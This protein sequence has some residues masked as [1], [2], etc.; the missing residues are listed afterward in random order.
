MDQA[1]QLD[2]LDFSPISLMSY[3]YWAFISYSSKDRAWGDW[4]IKAI[5]TYKVPKA[6]VGK[7]TSRGDP[8]PARAFPIFRDRDELPTETDLGTMIAQA[9]EQSRYLIVICSPN[10]ARS[11][12][13]NEEILTFKRLG[14]SDR[15]F[16][17]II[18]GS[19][20]ATDTTGK[21]PQLECYPDAL[22]FELGA[23][24]QL[25]AERTHPISADAREHG[26][27]KQN[28]LLKLLAGVL[29]VA[30]D[31]LKRRDEEYRRRQVL[32]LRA[33]VAGFALLALAASI[34]GVLAV[35]A[36]R[37]ATINLSFA[38]KATDNLALE[39]AR[40][41]ETNFNIP[42]REKLFFFGR[43]DLN[44]GQL[45]TRS[46]TPEITKRYA[47]L[48]ATGSLALWG[49]GQKEAATHYA[50][51]A[52]DLAFPSNPSNGNFLSS[53]PE[54]ARIKLAL[55]LSRI[56][57]M[58]FA[59]AGDALREAK[60]YLANQSAV[61][62]VILLLQ[63]RVARAQIWLH[64]LERKYD[65]AATELDH[66]KTTIAQAESSP[67]YKQFSLATRQHFFTELFELHLLKQEIAIGTN[68]DQP[69]FSPDAFQQDLDRAKP[70]F[71]DQAAS[72]WQF[73]AAAAEMQ[74]CAHERD[75]RHRAEAVETISRA[76]SHF[77]GIAQADPQNLRWR[78]ILAEALQIRAW[79]AIAEM[80]YP[81]AES[82]LISV[83]A[84]TLS[85][86]FDS[87]AH[88]SVARLD[89]FRSQARGK[90]ALAQNNA[91]DALR[92]FSAI[93]ARLDRPRVDSS[94]KVLT[95]SWILT[96]LRELQ[97][98]HLL[99]K[100]YP[101]ALA[102]FRQFLA[103]QQS[104]HP[105]KPVT[106][107][108]EYS[109]YFA[110]AALLPYTP[111]A[112]YDE[113]T[114]QEIF[115]LG[116][117]TIESALQREPANKPW[118]ERKAYWSALLGQH[119]LGLKKST[120]AVQAFQ[121]AVTS[122]TAAVNR[123]NPET[124]ISAELIFYLDGQ[125]TAQRVTVDLP[126][127]IETI[128]AAQRLIDSVD[129][130]VLARA[131]TP[132]WAAF[133]QSIKKIAEAS[134]KNASPFQ[135]QYA[136]ARAHAEETAQRL[137]RLAESATYAGIPDASRIDFRI[138][139]LAGAVASG[140]S[141]GLNWDAPPIYPAAWR[142]LVGTEITEAETQFIGTSQFPD[143]AAVKK[144]TRFRVATLPFYD[145]GQLLEAQY[146]NVSG[147]PLTVGLLVVNGEKYELY[148]TSIPI[149]T[150]NE[151]AP[152][153]LDSHAQVAAY[154]RFF[155]AHV[156]S[157][158]GSF[159]LVENA[160]DLPWAPDAPNQLRMDTEKLIRPVAVWP[161]AERPGWWLASGSVWYGN[162]L[163]HGL[164]SLQPSGMLE[165]TTDIPVTTTLPL[166]TPKF[167][168]GGRSRRSAIHFIDLGDLSQYGK[169]PE[170]ETL[171]QTKPNLALHQRLELATEAAILSNAYKEAGVIK[172]IETLKNLRRATAIHLEANAYTSAYPLQELIV[173][174]WREQI[175]DAEPGNPR[176]PPS[177]Q[178]FAGD[179]ASLARLALLGGDLQNARNLA[180]ES[181]A[182]NARQ[183]LA[184]IQLAHVTAAEGDE[185]T[186]LDIY[187]AE[188]GRMADDRPWLTLAEQELNVLESRGVNPR[189]IRDF[190]QALQSAKPS[191]PT[192]GSIRE[193]EPVAN[194]FPSYSTDVWP[195]EIAQTSSSLFND[196]NFVTGEKQDSILVV[197][198]AVLPKGEIEL[199]VDWYHLTF[200]VDGKFIA[201]LNYR[202]E[203]VRK[204]LQANDR[205]GLVE[206][207][208]GSKFPP[209]ITSVAKMKIGSPQAMPEIATPPQPFDRCHFLL[210]KGDDVVV[211]IPWVL[212][213]GKL[214]LYVDWYHLA[215]VVDE[216]IIARIRYQGTGLREKL[217]AHKQIGLVESMP[218]EAVPDY[219]T[220]VAEVRV[221][222]PPVVA[223]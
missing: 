4:L 48:L 173:K 220:S 6:L 219:V 1:A 45:A 150:A 61:N 82:D 111:E 68:P 140:A 183:P 121:A 157:D 105:G 37:Q 132:A 74:R 203:E 208:P 8:V 28:A 56:A 75:D 114:W 206:Y 113:A 223:P 10:S 156:R 211:V 84:L 178:E 20:N 176:L 164:F 202:G 180:L 151:K 96:G 218:G 87:S 53:G 100:D 139:N 15:I 207:P 11:K 40:E 152:I 217:Q 168:A 194:L 17:L 188:A 12:W 67:A 172:F 167:S 120:E 190:S 77:H 153:R 95:D 136:A 90:L 185:N 29:G 201:R 122:E 124:K 73:Y 54:A 117:D 94:S 71:A 7:S 134:I 32:R 60:A 42:T 38:Y 209:V 197:V 44:F 133:T 159:Q 109:R 160:I 64:Q 186:A 26:D 59:A 135:D 127:A 104:A 65:Q 126:G 47:E 187:R 25:T 129:T 85:L 30:Y 41:V 106:A 112:I 13:V 138:G 107:R 55:G 143:P 91:P 63:V 155:A 83:D 98:A 137:Q 23:D 35:Q 196:C 33:L 81:Q 27:G 170:L 118:L 166:V 195:K 214:V 147:L 193:P 5:E 14:R 213:K 169:T 144:I 36:K 97:R 181:L 88:L 57:E 131:V 43:L 18:D 130:P 165:L 128:V 79:L 163:F 222:A 115:R 2:T 80:D 162:T 22:R 200:V 92:A 9:L 177:L 204:R 148:G 125:L 102:V 50:E 198:P 171:L 19:P 86:K 215:F 69:A 72:L 149:H 99:K 78:A 116:S 184:R 58:R 16:S 141:N 103:R 34:A 142:T 110:C 89:Y 3:K 210:G 154:I 39:I 189:E 175:K 146:T 174:L 46:Q 51:R 31:D 52:H 66:A 24:G 205:I 216:K 119:L 145:N 182:I 158:K 93:I 179:L 192:P 212:P 123:D 221:G 161:D 49:V 199:Y 21:D 62:E 76:I 70:V 108:D 101:K 191:F